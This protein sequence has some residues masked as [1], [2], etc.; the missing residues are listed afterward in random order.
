MAVIPMVVGRFRAAAPR[1]AGVSFAPIQQNLSI[2]LTHRPSPF[3]PAC[4]PADFDRWADHKRAALPAGVE[5]CLVEIADWAALRPAETA[6]IQRVCRAVNFAIV[7]GPPPGGRESLLAL[8]LALGLATPDRHLCADP[9]GVAALQAASG[10]RRGDYIPYSNQALNWH[11]DG[12]YAPVDAPVRAFCL[13]CLRAAE[14]GGDNAVL[15]PEWVYLRLR[16]RRP[17]ALAGL[18]APDA[19]TLPPNAAL[20]GARSGAVFHVDATGDLMTRYTVRQ[21]HIRWS[22]AARPGVA[23]IRDLIARQQ[24]PIFRVRLEP[25]QALVCNNVW[26]TR[27][28]F[29]DHD[30]ASGRLVLRARFRERIANTGVN[31]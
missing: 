8:S 21:R 17:A 31:T 4:S 6:Q 20:R 18:F 22:A 24:V 23:D 7:S 10:E 26:H 29:R 13:M 9:D 28:A 25:G 2:V 19:L 15:D 5:Q 3:N 12:Y 16:E 27:Q 14:H 30:R 11:S 1:R